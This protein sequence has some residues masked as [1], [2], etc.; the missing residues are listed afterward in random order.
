V[1][2]NSI[3]YKAEISAGSLMPL[4][5]RRLAAFLLTE[6]DEI[7]WKRALVE[8]NILQK[9][10]PSTALRQARLIRDRLN[11]VDETAWDMIVNREQE[12]VIQVLLIVAIKHSQL[13]ADFIAD[14][15]IPRQRQMDLSI[16]ASDW[17]NFLVDCTNRDISVSG[18]SQSTQAKLFQVIRLILTEGKYLE[19]SRSM[20]LTPKSLHP[21]VK[22]YLSVREDTDLLNLLERA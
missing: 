16:Q 6:P 21:D 3:I 5:S 10:T 4:E 7:V 1:K 19:S 13:L 18:W 15:Y 14:V 11:T 12:V 20:K 22:K 8:E 2:Q 9:K 17:D